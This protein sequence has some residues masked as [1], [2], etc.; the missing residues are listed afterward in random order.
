M[1]TTITTWEDL[2]HIRKRFAM[3]VPGVDHAVK[4][5]IDNIVDEYLAGH[6]SYLG[7][8]IDTNENIAIV[9]DDGRGIPV[10]ENKDIGLS[11]FAIAYTKLHS[12]G[13]YENRA[14]NDYKFTIGLNGVGVKV[15]AATAK[16]LTVWTKQQGKHYRLKV[17]RGVLVREK[18]EAYPGVVQED[19]PKLPFKNKALST[20][21]HYSPDEGVFGSKE[22]KLDPDFLYDLCKSLQY[23]CPG[24]EI[25]FIL[26]G[27][28]TTFKSEEGISGLVTEHC[29]KEDHSDC[30]DLSIEDEQ[31]SCSMWWNAGTEGE[32]ILSFVNCQQ[33]RDAGTHVTGLKKAITRVFGEEGKSLGQYLREGL[34]CAIHLKLEGD[35]QFLGQYKHKLLDKRA[36]PIVAEIV[37][38]HLTV[39]LKNFPAIK[40]EI[41]SRAKALKRSH[42]KFSKE[43][44]ALRALSKKTK[45]LSLPDKLIQADRNC[46]AEERV[47]FICEGAS[48]AGP[49]IAARSMP[50]KEEIFQLKGKLPNCSRAN[51]AVVAKNAEVGGII[52]SVGC[53]VFDDCKPKKSR[54]G[55]IILM[56]DA[57]SDG[58]HINALL[59]SMFVSLMPGIIEAGMLYVLKPPLFVAYYKDQHWYGLN[60]AELY[61]QI[62]PKLHKNDNLII[63]RFKGHGAA[64]PEEV[65][66]Y[67]LG[68]N[69]KLEKVLFPD[70]DDEIIQDLMGE[71]VTSRK[72]LLG[73]DW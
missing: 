20:V 3:Y 4:E 63:N 29:K 52:Q 55:Q 47:L 56:S 49:L 57:D 68:P 17:E 12:S 31:L 73:I 59:I 34:R 41:L 15:T 42:E 36:E 7:V 27:D 5:A 16:V 58:E 32:V 11:S 44:E 64:N 61:K 14:D 28:I 18:K 1:T 71:D 39:F 38:K 10:T 70:G 50:L 66:E 24:L 6:C 40:D 46:P 26:D 45:K 8:S 65:K 69:R 30:E 19:L 23:L 13:K 62:P 43:Q 35:P 53:G 37:E 25:E 21:L 51:L 67:A 60:H 54:V 22:A 33:T 72:K 9:A 2:E 48:A